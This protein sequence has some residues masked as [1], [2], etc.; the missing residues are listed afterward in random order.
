MT[1]EQLDEFIKNACGVVGI[2]TRYL[3]ADDRDIDTGL[4]NAPAAK[5][6][7]AVGGDLETFQ[8]YFEGMDRAVSTSC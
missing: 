2:M 7:M 6:K 4:S 5:V 3:D 8:S 1:R